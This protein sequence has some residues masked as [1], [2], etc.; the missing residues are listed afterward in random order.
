MPS[1]PVC[2]NA[3]SVQRSHRRM[4]EYLLS[5]IGVLPYRCGACDA[6]FYRFQRRVYRIKQFTRMYPGGAFDSETPDSQLDKTGSH[7]HPFD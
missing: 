5:M 3:E 4:F 6:R 2:Q 1:C 7:P